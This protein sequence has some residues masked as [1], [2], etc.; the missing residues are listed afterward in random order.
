MKS[1]RRSWPASAILRRRLAAMNVVPEP[2]ARLRGARFSPRATFFKT[3]RI[4]ASS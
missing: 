3:A 4:A 1:A 2:V